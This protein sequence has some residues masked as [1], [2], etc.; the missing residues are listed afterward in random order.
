MRIIV[1]VLIDIC[2]K[3]EPSDHDPQCSQD[4]CRRAADQWTASCA[5]GCINYPEEINYCITLC[6]GLMSTQL[7]SAVM[8]RLSSL[9]PAAPML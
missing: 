3:R 6:S 7:L 4:T 1:T 5:S 8:M 2:F 9:L